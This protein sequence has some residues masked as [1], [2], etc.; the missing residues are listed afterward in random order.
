MLHCIYWLEKGHKYFF[1]CN[2]HEVIPVN[3]SVII[4]NKSTYAW[5][6][7]IFEP[8]AGSPNMFAP[9]KDNTE[10]AMGVGALFR[11]FQNA[12]MSGGAVKF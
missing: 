1:K 10:P 9:P 2:K 7:K 11:V 5:R 8:K 3:S 4:S 6:T 12:T